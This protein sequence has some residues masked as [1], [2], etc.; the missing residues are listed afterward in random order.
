M[1]NLTKD[2]KIIKPINLGLGY[3]DPMDIDL[4]GVNY[5]IALSYNF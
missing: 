1:F 5:S 2:L 4:T 3:K